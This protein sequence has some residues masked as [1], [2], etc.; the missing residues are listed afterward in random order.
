M[1]WLRSQ[2]VFFLI[3]LVHLAGCSTPRREKL[4]AITETKEG[5][6]AVQQLPDN[7]TALTG[8]QLAEIYCQACHQFPEPTLLDKATWEEGVLPAMGERLG[9][10]KQV[11][12]GSFFSGQ[13]KTK[14]ASEENAA[15]SKADWRK[16][17]NFYVTEA[18]A[19]PTAQPVKLKVNNS[20][21]LFRVRAPA[22]H[23]SRP[24]LTT[25]IRFD[26]NASRILVGSRQNLLYRLDSRTLQMVDSILTDTPPADIRLR[27]NQGLQLLTMGIMDPADQALGELRRYAFAATL[28]SAP[29]INLKNL[30]R[31][32]HFAFADL[33]QDQKEDVVICNFG[34]NSGGLVWYENMGNRYE[35][36]V[37]RALPGAR[38]AIIRD[39]NRDGL[40]DIVALMTQAQEGVYA[41]LNQKSGQFQEVCLLRFPPVYGSSDFE[42][43]D[44]NNDGAWD[45]LY[46][47]GDN[48]DL[49]NSLKNYHGVR[50]FLNNGQNK[51]QQAWFYPQYGSSRA[52]AHDFDQDGDLD[53][54][55][56]AFFPDFEKAPH[57]SFI[58]FNNQGKMQ[59]EPRTFEATPSGRWLTLESGDVDQDGDT[60]ILLGSFNF[61]PASGGAALQQK[62]TT[63]GVPF[64]I[65]ENKIKP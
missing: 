53:I 14:K 41:Y 54:A 29:K 28:P 45:I 22:F 59:F 55:A 43:V 57:E 16:I 30:A 51:F 31:P 24:P 23:Q 61:G 4:E 44:F 65:L 39:I 49:S 20:L 6:L 33:N 18:P 56:I 47:N 60:D 25:L 12:E 11:Q 2:T 26:P 17:I 34:N 50:I 58:Y 40:P 1:S 27:P 52:L 7:T 62:W 9:I 37:L 63:S 21:P 32:V 19:T 35:E 10:K 5:R 64:L 38:R 48:A 3:I 46:T 13:I 36:H 8:R 42:I 15:I